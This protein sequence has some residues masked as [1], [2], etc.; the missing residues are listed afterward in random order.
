[1]WTR[2]VRIVAPIDFRVCIAQLDCD[3]AFQL[4]LELHGV[5]AG[6][7]FDQG[8]LAM[9]DMANCSCFDF[10]AKFRFFCLKRRNLYL[11]WLDG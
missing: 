8:G 3:V 9:G 2:T 11:W 6:N 4:V 10:Y 7:R 5:H 1:M